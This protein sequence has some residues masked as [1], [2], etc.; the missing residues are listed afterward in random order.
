[1]AIEEDIAGLF[2]DEQSPML[3]GLTEIPVAGSTMMV[4][5]DSTPSMD[6]PD[7]TMTTMALPDP[8]TPSPT[9][10]ANSSCKTTALVIRNSSTNLV[11][12]QQTQQTLANQSTGTVAAGWGSDDEDGDQQATIVGRT[13]QVAHEQMVCTCFFCTSTSVDCQ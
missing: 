12:Y 2:E 6:M 5:M 3:D 9:V 4:T 10:S 13:P 1:M 7:G 11:P 8:P